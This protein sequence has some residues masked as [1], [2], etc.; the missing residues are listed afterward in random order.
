MIS[1]Q[2]HDDASGSE[3]RGHVLLGRGRREGSG[4]RETVASVESKGRSKVEFGHAASLRT[5]AWG[6]HGN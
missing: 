6:K 4:G 1:E 3:S 2:L 5:H